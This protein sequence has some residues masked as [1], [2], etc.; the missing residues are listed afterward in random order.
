MA[1]CRSLNLTVTALWVV[2]DSKQDSI[3]MIISMLDI[4]GES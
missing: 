1:D 3:Y 4:H 2:D